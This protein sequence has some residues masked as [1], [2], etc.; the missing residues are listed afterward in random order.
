[1]DIVG[2]GSLRVQYITAPEPEYL[3]HDEDIYSAVDPFVYL[4][5]T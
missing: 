2:I 4:I 1:M 5:G 3:R